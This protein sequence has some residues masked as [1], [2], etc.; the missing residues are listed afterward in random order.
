MRKLDEPNRSLADVELVRLD[1]RDDDSV[2][3]CVRTVLGQAGRIDVLVNNAGYTLLGSVEETSVKEARDL[4]ETNF[5]GVLRMTRAVLPI[6][7]DQNYGRIVNIGSVVGFVPAPYQ[8]IYSA[9]KHA[10]E[11]YT[12]SLDLEVRQFGIR[13]TV[14]EPGFTRTSIVQ[15]GCHAAELVAAYAGSRS[16]VSKAIRENNAKGADAGGVAA[17]ALDAVTNRS[18]RTRYP[19]GPEAKLA[20]R[21]RKLLP[22]RLF[23]RG[24][25]KQFGMDKA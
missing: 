4:F 17:V 16:L 18:P 10:L 14:I 8:A 2:R 23:E 12:E 19:V 13:A 24:L 25:R 3:S 1:V 5:F 7:R 9:T 6:M 22:A 11:G 20:S 15:N 21:L